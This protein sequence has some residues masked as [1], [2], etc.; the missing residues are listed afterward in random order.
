[1]IVL[2]LLLLPTPPHARTT[3]NRNAMQAC[4]AT[5]GLP[6]HP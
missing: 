4:W 3:H 1:M 2:T 5:T 6:F